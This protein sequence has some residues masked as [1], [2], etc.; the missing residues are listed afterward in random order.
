MG[1][2]DNI[3]K[4]QAQILALKAG[5]PASF[6]YLYEQWSGK[7]Y[8]FVMRISHGDSY[9]AEELVQS[10]FIKIWE[11]R[12]ELDANKSFGAYLCTIAKNQLANIY[13]HRMSEFLYQNE[14]EK[15]STI[16]NTTEKE[17]EY[18]LLDEYIQSL[19]EQLPTARREIFILSR[20]QLLSNKEIATKLNLSEN[21][22]ESQLTKATTFIRNKVMQ[23]YELCISI[24]VGLYIR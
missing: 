22:I 18:H 17:V 6:K 24:L 11:K 20:L 5:A 9:I 2:I 21:T 3:G 14:L 16:D 12:E 13:Q 15:T 4:D 8:N 7:L 1:D 10:V 23:H 19:I